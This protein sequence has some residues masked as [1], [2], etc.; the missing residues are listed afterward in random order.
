MKDMFLRGL[1]ESMK[2]L[3]SIKRPQSTNDALVTALAIE[4]S[5]ETAGGKVVKTHETGEC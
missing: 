1:P 3:V 5:E 2:K 4:V